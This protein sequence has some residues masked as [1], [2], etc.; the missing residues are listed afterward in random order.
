MSMLRTIVLNVAALR[1][2]KVQQLHAYR[3]SGIL[4]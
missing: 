2:M 3:L 1:M 4:T